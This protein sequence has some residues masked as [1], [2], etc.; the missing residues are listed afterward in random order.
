VTAA[1]AY[2]HEHAKRLV[3]WL[4]ENKARLKGEIAERHAKGLDYIASDPQV[5]NA[6]RDLQILAASYGAGGPVAAEVADYM[7]AIKGAFAANS[8]F[9]TNH[10]LGTLAAVNEVSSALLGVAPVPPGSSQVLALAG[11]ATTA[12]TYGFF[13]SP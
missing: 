5:K 12:Y 8:L 6:I 1:H 4:D 11:A 7:L 2:G 13:F 10:Y 9:A 3:K